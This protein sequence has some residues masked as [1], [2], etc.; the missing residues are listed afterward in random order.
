MCSKFECIE[1]WNRIV[2]E[3]IFYFHMCVPMSSHMG[4]KTHAMSRCHV[5]YQ[6]L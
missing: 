6:S 5:S 3:V 2:I 4:A 1:I